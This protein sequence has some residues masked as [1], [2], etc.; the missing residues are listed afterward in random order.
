MILTTRLLYRLDQRLNRLATSDHQQVYEEDK[1][2]ALNHAQI[3]LIKRKVGQNN[4]YGLG[5]DSFKKRYHD[6]QNLIV[7]FEE[8]SLLQAGPAFLFELGDLKSKC[9]FLCEM[10]ALGSKDNCSNRVIVATDLVKHGDLNL[11]LVNTNTAPSFE[12]QE[13]IAQLSDN[14]VLLYTDGSFSLNKAFVSYLRYPNKIST[15]NFVDFDGTTGHQDCEL[16][17]YLEDEL[18]DLALLELGFN[19]EN[20]SAVESANFRL[21]INE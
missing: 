4:I 18:L 16:V 12:Y 8:V 7:P 5:L 10:Y 9:M 13:T 20:Q 15:A 21:N 6:L 17:D 19:T 1:L 3:A 14:K 11:T 2:I